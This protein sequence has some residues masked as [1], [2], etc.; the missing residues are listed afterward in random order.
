MQRRPRLRRLVGAFAAALLAACDGGQRGSPEVAPLSVEP[1][2]TFPVVAAAL[3]RLAPDPAPSPDAVDPEELAG[4]LEYSL[5]ADAR[6]R[7]LVLADLERLGAGAAPLLAEW[8]S[9]GERDADL[10][11]AALD[12]LAAL[13]A[14]TGSAELL[15]LLTRGKP[16]WIRARAAWQLGTLADDRL[17]PDLCLRLKYEVDSETVVWIAWALARLGNY[18]GF[19]AVAV[20][21]G[22]DIDGALRATIADHLAEFGGEDGPATASGLAQFWREPPA[23]FPWPE[24]SAGYELALWRWIERLDEYQLRGVD[25]ARFVFA[26]QG[27]E[28]APLLAAALD[29]HSPYVRLHA[30]QGL[31]R[32]GARARR[33]RPALLAALERPDLAPAAAEALGAIGGAGVRE[34]LE[35]RLIPPAAPEL[36]LAAAR[37]LGLLA[38]PAAQPRLR[39]VRASQAAEARPFRELQQAVDEA[40]AY[41]GAGD[42]VA[43]ALLRWRA[44]P[45]LEPSSSE[46]A[47]LAWLA[48]RGTA[49]DATAAELLARHRAGF[50]DPAARASFWSAV[51][52]LRAP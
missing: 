46:R 12:G 13:G 49:G 29:D 30:A 20:V 32:M 8:A 50:A 25:D 18:S 26:H 9:D 48:A 34:A 42:E 36:R 40:L 43:G 22:R 24:R 31:Q 27:P 23:D 7:P 11:R 44:A 14:P 16:A 33:A 19:E 41:S 51:A 6:S 10:R 1:P 3:E 52:E 35:A 28:A 2:P 37:A 39:A 15:G 4:L 38:D 5:T 45:D 47:L 21:E 17:L